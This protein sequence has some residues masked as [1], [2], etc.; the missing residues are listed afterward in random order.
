MA[1]ERIETARLIVRRFE[2][3][4]AAPFD[5]INS[6]PEVRDSK[7]APRAASRFPRMA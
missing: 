3:R 6:D 1:L 2:P 7:I 5:A 4:D